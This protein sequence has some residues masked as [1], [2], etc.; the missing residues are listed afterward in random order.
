MRIFISYVDSDEEFAEDLASRLSDAGHEVW[1][2]GNRI[3]PGDNWG[4]K[5]GEALD[6]SDAMIVLLSPAAL[7]SN[8]VRGEISFA[9]G[10]PRYCDRLIP[11]QIATIPPENVPWI[12]G[13]IKLIRFG[14]QNRDRAVRQIVERLEKAPV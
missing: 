7:N 10:S 11:V 6:E 3:L 2:S 12:L 4:L 9:M 5:L 8:Q 14:P 1:Y 13:K